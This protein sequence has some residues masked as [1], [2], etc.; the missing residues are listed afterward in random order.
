MPLKIILNFDIFMSKD[1]R[2]HKGLNIKLKGVAEKKLSEVSLGQENF[3]LSPLDFHGIVPKLTVKVGHTV[4][5][6][7]TIFYNKMSDK[8]KFA[9]PV[10]GTISEIVRGEKRRILEVVISPDV[11]QTHK[12]FGKH[13]PMNMEADAV[14]SLL[15]EAGCLPFIK[16]RPYD[17]VASPDT[18]P[19]A[20]FISGL[21]TAPL[22]ADVAFLLQGREADFQTGVNVLS[23]LT[24]GGVH[25]SVTGK[26]Q[27]FLDK[28][29]HV[30]LHK[31]FGK[32][33]A[34]NVGVQINKIA[35][36]NKGEVVWTIAPQDVAVIGA[37]FNT[38]H[39]NP[40]R[41]FALAGSV[42]NQPQYFKAL[43]GQSLKD[44]LH[45]HVTS[46][47]V[48]VING[49]VLTGVK[50]SKEAHVGFYTNEMTV[51]PE[52]DYYT[53]FGWLPFTQNKKFSISRTFFSWLMPQK[54]YDL[55]TNMNGEE[56]A[57]VVTGEMESVMPMDI[58]PMQLIKAILSGN[59]DDME[60]LGI[61]EVA[62][63]DFALID[64]VSSSKVEAQSIVRQGLDLMIKEVG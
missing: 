63:E 26:E 18:E 43:Q 31:V 39:Y 61:Y 21:S 25:L 60:S 41:V 17:V 1:I 51:I 3:T 29:E 24:K 47:N 40:T 22:A 14:K 16:Q 12:D 54:T 6:G 9:S 32:H 23:K 19:R 27:T 30:T 15:S 62:P 28:T 10:S 48:R 58:Y 11:E 46:D 2:I 36:V 44:L 59:I 52:G 56:R 64:F 34:G 20:I 53:F 38:G 50:T 5:A 8:V 37:L 57:M 42:V 55:D 4:K 33:P 45:K 49:D 7:D 35:P 13:N